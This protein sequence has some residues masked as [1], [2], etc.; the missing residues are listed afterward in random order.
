MLSVMSSPAF[1]AAALRGYL[2]D[3]DLY[4][5]WDQ[6]GDWTV[7]RL[8]A[9][10]LP[11]LFQVGVGDV[12]SDRQ[13][14]DRF[15]RVILELGAQAT[16]HGGELG[17]RA[18]VISAELGSQFGTGSGL[19]L[20]R[21]R[22]WAIVWP[23]SE[24][25]AVQA[26]AHPLA[27]RFDDAT[28]QS[29]LASP[30]IPEAWTELADAASTPGASALDVVPRLWLRDFLQ[31]DGIEELRVALPPVACERVGELARGDSPNAARAAT[32]ARAL[33]ALDAAVPGGLASRG[34]W[35]GLFKASGL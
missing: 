17:Y 5:L 29:Y 11:L 25:P 15:G 1:D 32:V 14:A 23:E 27:A 21:A 33:G 8:R 4:A 30:G 18:G 22:T 7:R 12:Q 13:C 34:L 2:H 35:E 28:L 10:E 16:G 9:A 20:R 26:P 24:G 6:G 19:N 31:V 3:D